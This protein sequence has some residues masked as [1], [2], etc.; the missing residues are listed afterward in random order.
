[1]SKF[2][3]DEEVEEEIALLSKSPA[4]ALAR[5]ADR[6]KYRRRQQLYI[7]RDLEKRGRAMMEAGIT[8]E[9]LDQIYSIG[10]RD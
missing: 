6:I 7:L 8:R 3:T 2:L 9:Q 10:W 5:R 4:V 1:M